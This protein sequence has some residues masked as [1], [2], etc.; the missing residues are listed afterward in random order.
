MRGLVEGRGAPVIGAPPRQGTCGG[1]RQATRALV[2]RIVA[3]GIVAAAV[4]GMADDT[5]RA[6]SV[7]P[8]MLLGARRVAV[9]GD[10]ITYDGRWVAD[11]VAWMEREGT[12]AEVIDVG[13]PSETV[14]GLSEEG[15][16]NGSFPRPD[17][18][19]RLDRVLRVVRP[20][21]VLVC[22][23]MNCGIYRPLDEERFGRYRAGMERL[24]AA[25]E[26]AGAKV[27]HLTPPVYDA[28]PDKPGP[29]AD[30]FPAGEAAA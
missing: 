13:L 4:Q 16:A 1:R 23:G 11:L 6:G 18:A 29:A 24:H 30:F 28:R 19:E 22:Y 10:S 2:A 8:E 14:S 26:A 9:L 25:V 27:V 7:P 17:V 5:P 21:L 3:A 20:D 12:E 15:H